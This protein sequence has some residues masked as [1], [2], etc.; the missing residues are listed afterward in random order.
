MLTALVLFVSVYLAVRAL[1]AKLL[2]NLQDASTVWNFRSP[3]NAKDSSTSFTGQGHDQGSYRYGRKVHWQS[4]AYNVDKYGV[5]SVYVP[6]IPFSKQMENFEVRAYFKEW[7]PME[8]QRHA[9]HL[10]IDHLHRCSIES[11]YKCV[12]M[13]KEKFVANCKELDNALV[14]RPVWRGWLTPVDLLKN[15]I[16]L[17]CKRIPHHYM[18]IPKQILTSERVKDAISRAVEDDPETDQAVH[19][20]RAACIF[21]RMRAS[22]STSLLRV[23]VWFMHRIMSRMLTGVYVPRGQIDMIKRASEL[24]VP[25]VY[26]P[27]HRSHLDYILV[28]YLLY[29]NDMRLPL[30]AAGDNLLIPLF[31]Q[32]LRGLGGFFIKR[33]LDF[34]DGRKDHVY[35]AVLKEYMR[36]ILMANHS[37]EFFLEGGRSRTGKTRL[38]KAGLLSVIVDSFYEEP[39][40]DILIVPISISYEKLL[41]GNFVSEQLGEPKVMETFTAAL[42][43]IWKI[44]HSNYG[45]VRVDFCQPFSLM[46]FLNRAR[47]SSSA[48][49]YF[50]CPLSLLEAA[51][52]SRTVKY[53]E[54]TSTT[55]LSSPDGTS[56]ETRAAIKSLANHVVHQ[57]TASLSLM[58]TSLVAFLLLTKHRKGGTLQQLADSLCWL[59]SEARLHK[60]QVMCLGDDAETVRRACALLGKELVISETVQMEWSSGDTENN[61]VKIVFYRPALHLPS[62]LELQYYANAVLPVFVPE[63]IVATSLYALTGEVTLIQELSPLVISKRDLLSKCQDLI[64]ILQREFV[65][66][67]PCSSVREVIDDAISYFAT[68]NILCTCDSTQPKQDDPY[69][70]STDDESSLNNSEYEYGESREYEFMEEYSLVLDDISLMHLEFLRSVLA[71]YIESY[72]VVACSLFKLV[73]TPMEERIFFQEIQKVA[74][75]KLQEGTLYYEES[76]AADTLHNAVQLYEQWGIVE[77]HTQDCIRVLYLN[78]QWNV[79]EAINSVISFVGQFRQ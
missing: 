2:Q 72:W 1:M 41:D 56:E 10:H 4:S 45:A 18:P 39:W 29:L 14:V 75:D 54:C 13:S 48:P 17:T 25:M 71:S 34:K 55:S 61:N 57:S 65:L 44:L 67:L 69:A 20:K 30:V 6:K 38:P 28:T 42:T 73:G 32:L 43:S 26:L 35:R 58:S 47:I 9:D 46:E 78:E 5:E 52:D 12:P 60:R 33:R 7:M 51:K 74:Q 11:C 31:G 19:S 15:S 59:R 62:V 63:A 53:N 24:N 50:D 66:V 76:F 49:L 64:N 79:D 3:P 22:I 40:K 70:W 27:L 23:A 16:Y 21:E 77:H 68:N 37:L 36:E 8:P